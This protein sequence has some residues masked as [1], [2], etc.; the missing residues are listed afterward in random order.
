[1]LPS[2]LSREIKEGIKRFLESTFPP[3]T[4]LFEGCLE[5]LLDERGAVFKG[6]YY[7]LRLPFRTSTKN[8]SPF[9]GIGFPYRP[10]L[11]QALAFDRL[12]GDDPASTIVATGTGSG[13]TECFLYPILDYCARHPGEKGIKAIVLYPMNALATDQAKRFAD[14]VHSDDSLRGKLRVG[15]YVGGEADDSSSMTENWV[16]TSRNT[17]RSNPPDILLTNYKMLDYLLIRPDDLDLWADN[18]PETLKFV[19]VD[20]LHTFD[21]AQATD[22][23]C[24]LRRLKSRL[25]TPD[26][27]LCCVGTSATIGSPHESA[28]LLEYASTLFGESFGRADAIIQEHLLSQGEFTSGYYIRHSNVPGEENRQALRPGAYQGQLDYLRGQYRLW[29][30]KDAPEDIKTREWRVSLGEELR[31]HSLLRNLLVFFERLGKRQ[32]S[33]EELLYE[34]AQFNAELR[35]EEL[36]YQVFDSLCSLCGFARYEHPETGAIFPFLK[37]HVHLWFRELSR[38][39]A[40]V[41]PGGP[42]GCNGDRERTKAPRLRFSNE[43]K[44]EELQSSLPVIHCRECGTMGWGGIKRASEE[45]LI[46]DLDKFYQSFFSRDPKLRLIFPRTDLPGRAEP[47]FQEVLCG[48]CLRLTTGS[49]KHCPGC[50]QGDRLVPVDVH[51]STLKRKDRLLADRSCPYCQ[52]K[53]GIT[54]LGSRSASLSSVALGQAFAT[55]FNDDKQTLAFSDNVQDAS[56]RASFF[57]ARTYRTTLRT[58]ICEALDSAPTNPSIDQFEEHFLQYW[59]KERNT[60]DFIGTFLAPNME[61]LEDY[62]TLRRKNRLSSDSE[63]LSLVEKRLRWELCAEFGFQARIGRTLEKSG[64]AIGFLKAQMIRKAGNRLAEIL[65]EKSGGFGAVKPRQIE[66]FLLGLIHRL[67]TIGGVDHPLIATHFQNNGDPFL[68]NRLNWSPGFSFTGRVPAAFTMGSGSPGNL[69]RVI[70]TGGTPSWLQRWAM[71]SLA[72]RGALSKEASEVAIEAALDCLVE[73]GVLKES[74]AKN[75]NRVWSLDP[76]VLFIS[77]AVDQMACSHCGHQISAQTDVG[78]ELWSHTPCMRS[79]CPGTY[80]ER[81]QGLNYFG[82]LYRSGDV[83]RIH[84]EEH[85]GLIERPE[86]EWIEQRFMATEDKRATDPNL[87]SCTP[88]LEM[89]IDIGDLSTVLLCSVPPA[90]SNYLQRVGRAGRRDGNAF[91][92]T[93]ANAQSHDLYFYRQPEDMM[94]GDVQ[95]P[96]VFLDA[97]AVLERQ[98]LA[99]CFDRWVATTLPRPVV[100]KKINQALLNTLN[101]GNPP[102]GFPYDLLSYVQEHLSKLLRDFFEMFEGH[103]EQASRDS[104]VAFVRGRNTEEGSLGWKI[105]ARLT[106]FANEREDL[107]KR[108]TQIRNRLKKL[109]ALPAKDEVTLAEID[110]LSRTAKGLS[111]VIRKI[112]DTETFQFF[113]DEGLLPNY[114]FPEEGVILRSIILR[115]KQKKS[116]EQGG[117]YTSE[118]LEYQRPAASAIREL[119]P[120]SSFYAQHRRLTVDQVNLRLSEPELWNFCDQ[121]SYVEQ[122]EVGKPTHNA[123]PVCG[124]SNWADSSMRRKMIPMRQ[125]MTTEF[126]RSS[127]THDELDE[128]SPEFFDNEMSVA[129]PDSEIQK[130]YQVK[131]SAVPFGFEF[132]RLATLRSINLGNEAQS[133]ESTQIAGKERVAAGFRLCPK[134]GKVQGA[135][136]NE[137]EFRHDIACPLRGQQTDTSALEAFFLYR[138]L[139]SEALRVLVPSVGGQGSVELASFVAALQLGLSEHFRGSIDHLGSCLE[140][141]PIP[142]T[143]FKRT[144]LIIYD[145]V[146][147]GTGY[148]KQLSQSADILLEILKKA[149]DYLRSCQCASDPD[150]DGCHRCVLKNQRTRRSNDPSRST[151]IQIL[152]HIL[153]HG[154]ELEEISS[155]SSIDLN[156]LLESQLEQM[157]LEALDSVENATL[158]AELIDGKDAYTFTIGEQTWEVVPQVL[159][160]QSSSIPLETKPD[161]VLRPVRRKASLPIALY[162]DGFAFHADEEAGKNRI[163][164]DIAQREGLRRSGRWWVWSLSWQDLTN[165]GAGATPHFDHPGLDSDQVG[166]C[167]TLLKAVSEEDFH[168]FSGRS[169]A[170]SWSHLLD[171]LR[172][173]ERNRWT[174]HAYCLALSISKPCPVDPESIRSKVHTLL[175]PPQ[176]CDSGISESAGSD[177]YGF[178]HRDADDRWDIVAESSLGDLG[179]R[180]PNGLRVLVRFDDDSNLEK[181]LLLEPWQGLLRLHN[182]LQFLPGVLSATVRGLQQG[183]ESHVLDLWGT[184]TVPSVTEPVPDPSAWQIDHSL[185]HPDLHPLLS[186]IE[187]HGLPLPMCGFELLGSDR[188]VVGEAELAWESQKVALLL[189]DQLAFE[190][191]FTRDQWTVLQWEGNSEDLTNQLAQLLS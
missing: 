188:S 171:Y 127:R 5:R 2:V 78:K 169:D 123:C 102:T 167:E 50:G 112:G 120:G 4:P 128:R 114:A 99:F 45:R 152:E 129:I 142:E 20:E 81:P 126:D 60:A 7:S 160:E 144:Y 90:T 30:G 179:K 178:H 186:V 158:K 21:G 71:K 104:L 111:G 3:S 52:S 31:E 161:F 155:L 43:L 22:L 133:G 19:V 74:S 124:S 168:H 10:H 136:R 137:K 148:L 59:R 94:D 108:R 88:T 184:P 89:G 143:S 164:K 51:S 48:H 33:E 39:V 80:N 79:E 180:D 35:D 125:V 17:M 109:E 113:T 47:E 106:E 130:A 165:R 67:R 145:K 85:T 117:N 93:V 150:L 187:G 140:T 147:G 18:H 12:K 86:R 16:I 131:Q 77:M 119:A 41:E 24:L 29:F 177:C 44:K 156:P 73:E 101:P 98:F 151:G 172:A 181:E 46:S 122:L 138:E 57:A 49:P 154:T 6:P 183:F 132:V 141:R 162:L 27:H 105:I 64:A 61:W 159:I 170:S 100:P 96:G 32:V 182:L 25:G 146:P 8:E 65:R 87:L 185:V 55:R 173:P 37:V 14:A 135:R 92:L 54:I 36:A 107:R 11:H 62:E 121:C 191:H 13:K 75:G 91:S 175:Q 53:S 139:S 116:D 58:A 34:L 42:V 189:S 28:T 40:T 68:I 163:G 63:L 1:M 149:Y 15:M 72:V 38:M 56:H 118:T 174:N 103:L 9:E 176:S 23:G 83:T 190:A 115:K 84:A 134:C 66:V 82:E 110:E 95:V 166:L 97:P 153:S 26:E 70:A 76:T 69:E 157:F